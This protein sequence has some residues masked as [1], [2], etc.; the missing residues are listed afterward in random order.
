MCGK[1]HIGQGERKAT[2]RM[3]KHKLT[4]RKHDMLPLEFVHEDRDHTF[5]LDEV[6]IMGRATVR[7][8]SLG[9]PKV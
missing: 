1:C 3:D 8:A 7:H 2:T 4:I 9:F 5:N 6:G